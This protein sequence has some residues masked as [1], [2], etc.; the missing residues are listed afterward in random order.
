M[1]RA[2][3]WQDRPELEH[4][5]DWWR[6]IGGGL[7]AL[8]AIGGAGKTA[9]IDRFLQ[10]VPGGSPASLDP[11]KAPPRRSELPET[12]AP[13]IFSFY[14]V[15]NEDSFF[16][17]LAGWLSRVAE[18]CRPAEVQVHQPERERGRDRRCRRPP[19]QIRT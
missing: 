11:A 17:E 3:D 9:T 7:Y 16:V 2:R 12:V 8:V 15:P 19:A 14:D 18:D 6:N 10:I 4:L 13:F 1:L 5:C